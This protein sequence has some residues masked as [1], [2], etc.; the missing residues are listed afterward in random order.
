MKV[1]VGAQVWM[2]MGIH[3]ED[4]ILSC[5]LLVTGA[6]YAGCCLLNNPHQRTLWLLLLEV[7]ELGARD[8]KI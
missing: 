8:G 7:N 4:E 3:I 6:G 2:K 1:C 5:K